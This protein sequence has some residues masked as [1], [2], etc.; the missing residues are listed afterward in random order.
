MLYLR[1]YKG[2]IIEINEEKFTSEKELYILIWKT[3]YNIDISK[4]IQNIESI[5]KYVNGHK[6]FV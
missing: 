4:N 6:I 3:K 2:K 5:L 1:N